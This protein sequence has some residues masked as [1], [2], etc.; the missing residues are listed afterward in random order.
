MLFWYV[1]EHWWLMIRCHFGQVEMQFEYLSTSAWSHQV[2]PNRFAVNEETM[3]KNVGNMDNITNTLIMQNWY[4]IKV[5]Q[6]VIVSTLSK[7]QRSVQRCQTCAVLNRVWWHR[8]EHSDY[9]M[10]RLNI[11]SPWWPYHL[12]YLNPWY[13]D[14][15]EMS[16]FV[17]STSSVTYTYKSPAGYYCT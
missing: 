15:V 8:M 7:R 14:V 17:I 11:T 3:H 10:H 12:R 4:D 1:N 9:D 6:P 16:L 13:F 5:A 2:D